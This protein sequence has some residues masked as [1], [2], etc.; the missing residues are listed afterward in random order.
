MRYE[1]LNW[2]D[3]KLFFGSKLGI[4]KHQVFNPFIGILFEKWSFALGYGFYS[5]DVVLGDDVIPITLKAAW[6]V[7]TGLPQ[8]KE[9]DI[10]RLGLGADI[11]LWQSEN[12]LNGCST[13]D[14]CSSPI[15]GGAG[16]FFRLYFAKGFYLQPGAYFHY[17]YFEKEITLSEFIGETEIDYIIPDFIGDNIIATI[18]WSPVITEI[19]ILLGIGSGQFKFIFGLLW[20]HLIDSFI[21]ISLATP[22][23][24]YE[25]DEQIFGIRNIINDKYN[26]SNE[27]YL[28]AGLDIDIAKHFGIG[29]K[30][31]IP[32]SDN[33]LETYS[34]RT[35]IYFV[36]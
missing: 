10:I 18:T 19:P 33:K 12:E 20:S 34:F 3:K 6:E 1:F 11:A 15:G 2:N 29:G 13:F 4:G 28:I 5:N 24:D 17:R 8:K 21:D 25:L 31:L 9:Y 35:S 30:F 36:L 16:L 14:K 26:D 7:E 32:V 23:G 27:Y 22:L